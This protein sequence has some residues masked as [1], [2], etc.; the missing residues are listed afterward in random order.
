MTADSGAD[1][2]D[3]DHAAVAPIPDGEEPEAGLRTDALACEPVP[4]QPLLQRVGTQVLL[5]HERCVAARSESSEPGEQQLVQ[6]LLADPDR[7]IRPDRGEAEVGRDVVG[8]SHD[9]VGD[10]VALGVAGAELAGATVDVDGPHRGVRGT[11][12]HR[13]CDGPGPTPEVEKSAAGSEGERR[14][15]Q[16]RRGRVEMTVGEHPAIGLHRE[17]GVGEG[18]VDDHG[19]GRHRRVGVEVL[20][21]GHSP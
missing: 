15:Q 10:P 5:D 4:D 8:M 3:V 12:S 21:A 2:I 20:V 16:H 11:S 19:S 14:P 17:G 6:S 1:V 18:D 9:D 13:Q 7:R